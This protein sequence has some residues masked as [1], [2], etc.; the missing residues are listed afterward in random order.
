MSKILGNELDKEVGNLED[1]GCPKMRDRVDPKADEEMWIGSSYPS[2]HK[3]TL[4]CAELKFLAKR[5]MQQ[6]KSSIFP[7]ELYCQY[8]RKKVLQIKSTFYQ[9]FFAE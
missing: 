3:T 2:K 7:C 9:V 1:H 5:T 4:H 6:L 8:L